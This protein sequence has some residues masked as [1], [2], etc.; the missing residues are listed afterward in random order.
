VGGHKKRLYPEDLC[1]ATRTE[2]RKLSDM[3]R[4]MVA[5]T[6]QSVFLAPTRKALHR[7]RGTLSKRSVMATGL[8]VMLVD[9]SHWDGRQDVCGF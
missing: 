1:V 5:A 3:K 8:G 2:A 6:V 4:A 9:A 7:A